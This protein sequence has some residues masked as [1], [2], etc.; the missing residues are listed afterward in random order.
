[1]FPLENPSKVD[2]CIYGKCLIAQC[3]L[4][5]GI[6]VENFNGIIVSKEEIPL[7][8]TYYALLIEKEKWVIPLTN[9]RYMNHSCDPNCKINDNLDVVTLRSVRCKEELTISY[10]IVYENEEPGFWDNRW[11]FKCLCRAKNCQ[12]IIDKYIMPNGQ[13]W[14]SKNQENFVP[15]LPII[16]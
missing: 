13:P 16:I 12:G 5:A 1:M 15:L 8:E 7:E 11:T 4:P 6:I 14:I 10:N 9:A 3:D 2:F